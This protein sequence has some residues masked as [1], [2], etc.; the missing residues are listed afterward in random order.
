MGGGWR[1]GAK[2]GGVALET[3]DST[4]CFIYG[5]YFLPFPFPFFAAFFAFS[6]AIFQSLAPF[7][8]P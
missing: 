6:P 8:F 2:G 1:D 4:S 5:V 7:F 3:P